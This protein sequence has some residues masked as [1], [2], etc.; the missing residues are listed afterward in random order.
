MPRTDDSLP[1]RSPDDQPRADS[2]VPPPDSGQ[3]APPE[4]DKP[5]L[6]PMVPVP[7]LTAHPGNIR[8]DLDLSPEFVASIQANGVLVPLRITPAADGGY[9]VID[10][11]RR[12]AAAVKARLDE[13][14]ADIAS[15]RAGDEAGQYLDMWTAHRHRNP[16]QPIEE[17][18]ALFAA[19]EAGATKARIRK[20]TGLK[21]S[22]VDAALT[23]SRLS[24]G[25]RSTVEALPYEMTLEDLAIFAEFDDDPAAIARLTDI[26]KWGGTL[27]HQAELLRQERAEAAENQRL[28]RELATAGFAV[29][30]G[31]PPGA[32]PLTDLRHDGDDL[33][34]EGHGECPG[35][36][37]F[38]RSYDLLTPVHYCADPAA[39]GHT[40]RDTQPVNSGPSSA[41][42]DAPDGAEGFGRAQPD[43]SRRLVIEGNKAWKAASEVRKRW[44]S[45]HLFARRAAPREAAQ[46]AARQLLT[47]PDPLR[48]NLP[49]AH[50]RLLFSEIT[51]KPAES[52]LESC[53]TVAAGRVPLLILG[54]IVTAY[55]QAV[56]EGEGKNT[57]RQDRY[58]PCPRREAGQYLA[59]LASVGYPLSDIEQTVVDGTAYSGPAVPDSVAG[60]GDPASHGEPE[61]ADEDVPDASAVA[62]ENGAGAA[63]ASPD[64][65]GAESSQAAA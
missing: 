32:Q 53:D 12:L 38:F 51:G 49:V 22:Q 65:S 21:A 44:L 7:L 4:A 43:T 63:D 36:G 35:R 31:L 54:P 64:N 18:D 45:T 62:T 8:R 50:S 60:D 3:T 52:W 2:A 23:A 6:R 19:R 39:H 48:S 28:R 11:H 34:A 9:R 41:A 13:V 42:S 27:D 10:G 15:D 47:M 5:V 56:T 26:A 40:I 59:F 1:D 33:T 61:P 30:E 58:S 46:F 55:E 20:S 14:P 29:A 16:L 25:T 24:D 37:V 57:W 17:A